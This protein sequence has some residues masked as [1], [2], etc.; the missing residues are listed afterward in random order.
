MNAD[1]MKFDVRTLK[2]RRRRRELTEKEVAARLAEL[3][4]EAAEAES[5]TTQF[6]ATFEE[7]NYRS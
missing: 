6:V 4:D 2:Y 1:E 7:R 3:P 5:T